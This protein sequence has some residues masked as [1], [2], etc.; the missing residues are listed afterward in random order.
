MGGE[1]L[2]YRSA[3]LAAVFKSVAGEADR[4]ARV[5]GE[6]GGKAIGHC[7]LY[8][9]GSLSGHE[10]TA[11]AV[12]DK[13]PRHAFG[14]CVEKE[15]QSALKHVVHVA[16]EA[17]CSASA[18]YYGVLEFSGL[19]QHRAL[20]AAEL[21]FPFLGEDARYGSV[22]SLL[23]IEVEVDEL[24]SG[25]LRESPAESGLSAGH[26][27]DY[28]YGSCHGVCLCCHDIAEPE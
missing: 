1:E 28:E 3:D 5:V 10:R 15:R 4:R 9:V 27:A 22:E 25:G 23:D 26:V 21:L 6:P 12:F 20:D 16:V 14:R 7:G 13:S 11:R 17:W 19:P 18:G 24:L 8:L 2:F